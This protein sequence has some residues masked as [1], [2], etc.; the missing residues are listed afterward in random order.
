MAIR[1]ASV[2]SLMDVMNR[3]DPGGGLMDIAEILTQTHEALDDIGWQEG[4]LVTGNRHGVRTGKPDVAWGRIN[5]GTPRSKSTTAQVDEAAAQL[6]GKAQIDRRLAILSGN[7]AEYRMQEGKS[8]IE[9]MGDEFMQT[10][11]YGNSLIAD[12]E[13]TGLTPRFN[14]AANTQVIDAGGTGTDN[15][16]IWLVVWNDY[17]KGIYPKGSKGGLMH[18]DT[19]ANTTLGPDGYPIGDKV[20]DSNGYEYL[21]YTDH[22]QWDCGLMIR[23]PRYVVRIANI[24]KSLL[25]KDRATGGDL[26]DLLIQALGRVHNLNGNASFYMDR[27]TNTWFDRQASNDGR[28][29]NG[30]GLEGFSRQEF[31]K[32]TTT[33]TFRGIPLRREDALNVD[34]AR[35]V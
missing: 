10:L 14:S 1:N 25:S 32:G 22:W 26:Q 7:A 9:A 15:R 19:T 23:D 6:I 31:R 27:T 35:V 33:L 30:M 21:A 2:P 29:F 4:N 34:E 8:F 13:Y 17:V 5:Q 12:N 24:D 3:L 18:M 16:S 28:A 20:L 11:F